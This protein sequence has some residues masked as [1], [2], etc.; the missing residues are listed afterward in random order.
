VPQRSGAFGA[1][2]PNA[3]KIQKVYCINLD[4]QCE[5]W[6]RVQSELGRI[7]EVIGLP[8]T[9]MLLRVS[10]I[11][12]RIKKA[13]PDRREIDP[14]YTLKEQLFVEPQP[15]L[16]YLDVEKLRPIQ[17]S[18]EEI[19]VAGSHIAV[20][21]A[22]ADGKAEYALVL[23]DDIYFS[24]SFAKCID[25]AWD[26]LT[27]PSSPLINFDFL[28]LS[29][30]EAKGRAPKVLWS[31]HLFR[32]ISGL[33]YLSG[34]VL[35]KS[36][37]RKLLSRLPV[38][39]PVDLWMNQQF[40]GMEVFATCR[41]II[42]QNASLGSDNWYS[43]VPELLRLGALSFNT[44]S[45]FKAR[46][47][48]AP[49]FVMGDHGKVQ[50]D[51]AQALSMLG[52]RCYYG[53]SELDEAQFARLING[54]KRFPFD[55]IVG[56]EKLEEFVDD[57]AS[58]YPEARF[59]LTVE[60]QRR[61]DPDKAGGRSTVASCSLRPACS[62]HAESL[63]EQIAAVGIKPMIVCGDNDANWSNL[64]AFLRCDPPLAPYPALPVA[65][66][67]FGL[68]RTNGELARFP[69]TRFLKQDS[70]PSIVP[71]SAGWA[72][73]RVAENH[74]V[75]Q[76]VAIA[77]HREAAL[78]EGKDWELL[79]DTFPGNLAL[80]RP[81]NVQT[82]DEKR[83]VLLV[84]REQVG[85][86]N[87]TS[88]SIRSHRDF[89]FG[90]FETTV[91]PAR[92]S[93]LITGLFLQRNSPRQEIDIEFLGRD[94]T[95]MLV[96]VFFNP[97]AEGA[98]YDYGDR[99]TPALIDLDFD[100]ADDFHRYRIEWSPTYIRWYVDGVVV[101]ERV[102]WNPT[103]VPH[104]S[105]KYYLNLWPCQSRDLAGRLDDEVLPASAEIDMIKI[106]GGR[107]DPHLSIRD[108]VTENFDS[109]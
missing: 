2:F 47:L 62:S 91:K 84:K 106:R 96:N 75:P 14:S 22:I 72:G 41:P 48:T 80:F 85:V 46:R 97:G 63:A 76:N 9:N 73:I 92:G 100:A 35:S 28:Y 104:L 88:G 49:V 74:F 18:P 64:C 109:V 82:L 99:G 94:T 55:A 36:G 61:S 17:M 52:Y 43:V 93:G 5:R 50:S 20:W 23:E 90:S 31:R 86:R 56:V 105:M 38:R 65:M 107:V 67:R 19:A 87:Y 15:L 40:T 51:L 39:G 98:R 25:P 103:P 79:S 78:K 11:D 101:H 3:R 10:A 89:L 102:P 6:K 68:D 95:R 8:L 12:A 1:K 59:I 57:L 81:A 69:K 60:N 4:R 29:Y 34:Y 26:E 83:L 13:P 27:G 53:S 16:R 66:S 33:W 45:C 24:P 7:R 71:R 58:Q 70:S 108:N 37:A 30:L 21:R 77:E 32:P 54:D 42:H 44:A